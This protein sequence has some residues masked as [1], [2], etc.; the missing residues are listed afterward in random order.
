[1]SATRIAKVKKYCLTHGLWKYDKYEPDVQIYCVEL[2]MKLNLEKSIEDSVE[3]E[4]QTNL[5]G[6]TF[7]AGDMGMIAAFG[8]ESSSSQQDFPE[9][10]VKAPKKRARGGADAAGAPENI[11][12]V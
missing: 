8:S 10:A 5:T 1:M 12:Q 6:G 7:N 9:Q 11:F 3:F 4:L 2:H